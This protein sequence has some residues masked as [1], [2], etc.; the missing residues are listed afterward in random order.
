MIKSLIKKEF[1]LTAHPMTFVMALFGAMLLIPSYPYYI[2]FFYT[3]LGI[4][5]GFMNARENK[6]FVY[7][8]VLPVSKKDIVKA[9]GLFVVIIELI[10]IAV[11][12]PF[13]FITNRINPNPDLNE[14][15]INANTAFFGMVLI[16][17]A[18]FN[19]IFLTTFFKSAYKV[20]K[21]FIFSCI[22]MA[23]YMVV[24]EIPVIIYS[25]ASKMI[26]ED[27]QKFTSNIVTSTLFSVGNLMD[28][29]GGN[30]MIK[31]LPILIAGIIIYIVLTVLAIKKSQSNFEKVDL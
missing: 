10:S 3:T 8:A 16:M 1:A 14:A 6:D 18:I 28:S 20:G 2:A 25:A 7:M 4:F 19:L 27:F 5:F 24:A 11:A 12:V 21:A 13:A 26:S 15:G 17:F 9:K 22:G 29:V 30:A 31:Q 23:A